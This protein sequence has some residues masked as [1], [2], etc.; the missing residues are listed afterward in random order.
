M[1]GLLEAALRASY[2]V[3]PECGHWFSTA[4]L[5]LHDGAP[6]C[7]YCGYCPECERAFWEAVVV[8]VEEETE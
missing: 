1:N 3:C 2:K 4:T 6:Y 7:P 8:E 5:C